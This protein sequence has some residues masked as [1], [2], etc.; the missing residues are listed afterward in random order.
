MEHIQ[1]AWWSPGVLY[2]HLIL[3]YFSLKKRKIKEKNREKLLEMEK[4]CK[5]TLKS[6]SF[7]VVFRCSFPCHFP[8][9]FVIRGG[10]IKKRG[11]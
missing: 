1:V 6:D 9:R 10:C 3:V 11:V 8:R 7:R 5:R 2:Q 4:D